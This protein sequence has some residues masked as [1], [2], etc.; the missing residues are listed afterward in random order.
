M[1]QVKSFIGNG[2]RKL[3]ERSF[4]DATVDL[5]VILEHY[6]SVYYSQSV[7][8]TS[9]YPGV[10]D[11]LEQLHE[12]GIVST[13]LTNKPGGIS[14]S[15]LEEL[16][17]L[18]FFKTVIGAEDGYDLKPSS[19]GLRALMK[20]HKVDVESCWMIGDH[21]TDLVA[22]IDSYVH[23]G[24]VSYGFGHKDELKPTKHFAS[25]SEV[26]EYFLQS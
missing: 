12:T 18:P 14:R 9:I 19:E 7:V 15:I 1:E 5:S 11:G 17:L 23:T 10:K 16:E 2:I 21:H 3:V 25:F 8:H 20:A 22:G 13:V 4:A 24:F 6:R 26:V